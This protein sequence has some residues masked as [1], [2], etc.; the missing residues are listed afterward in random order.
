MHP[1]SEENVLAAFQ[2]KLKRYSDYLE[3]EMMQR[4]ILG[5]SSSNKLVIDVAQIELI[6]NKGRR[7]AKDVKRINDQELYERCTWHGCDSRCLIDCVAKVQPT[8]ASV[9]R[10]AMLPDDLPY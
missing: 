9:L 8:A 2:Q 5:S 1:W 10:C 7:D 4:A 6:R 3:F